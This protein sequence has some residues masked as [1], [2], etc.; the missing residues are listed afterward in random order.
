M[1]LCR[2][3]FISHPEDCHFLIAH[4]RGFSLFLSFNPRVD[5]GWQRRE[6]CGVKVQTL[7]VPE[8]FESETV[9]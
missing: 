8:N 3:F 2:Y 1:F 4:M 5:M 9:T 6:R 7:K